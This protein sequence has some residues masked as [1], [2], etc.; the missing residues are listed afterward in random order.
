M[1]I[2]TAVAGAARGRGAKASRPRR[3]AYATV[4]VLAAVTLIVLSGAFLIVAADKGEDV[5]A[6]TA[7][8][9]KRAGGSA[10]AG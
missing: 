2:G 4:V 7:R 9:E 6:R 3:L 5:A 1:L 10:P 8:S